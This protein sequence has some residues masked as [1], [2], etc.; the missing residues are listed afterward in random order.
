MKLGIKKALSRRA[1]VR[2]NAL[3]YFW[4]YGTNASRTR[5]AR[6]HTPAY[7]DVGSIAEEIAREGIVSGDVSKFLS[8]SGIEQYAKAKREILALSRSED[9]QRMVATQNA[10][11]EIKHNASKDFLVHMIAPKTVHPADGPIL[12]L[13]LDPKLLEV[14]SGYL[15]LWP[16]L[17][18]IHAW[19]NYPTEQPPK[20]SQMWHRDPED[21]RVVKAF[22]YLVDVDEDTGPF[23][24]IPRTHPFGEFAK[25]V[26]RHKDRKRVEDEEMNPTLS[27][28]LHQIC[29]GP[30][31][32]MILA[33]TVGYHRGGKP[34]SKN[35]VLLTF[36]YT[37][38]W[39][40]KSGPQI[41]GTPTWPM[42]DMQRMA[43]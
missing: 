41:D 9:V 22:I 25:H 23:T 13:A 37:S 40:D 26:P 16:R 20:E 7:S 15:G 42:N 39:Q 3:Y 8:Q 35:R 1:L 14:V 6:T 27:P 38:A 43:L 32:T 33:D 17:Y 5:A 2:P 12:K 29:T 31:D 18:Q 4:K 19:L 21:L 36:T 34:K 30:A 24:F 28:D 11:S 10:A